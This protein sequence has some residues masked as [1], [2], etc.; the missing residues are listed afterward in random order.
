MTFKDLRMMRIRNG[1][2]AKEMAERLNVSYGWS[3]QLELYYHGP[4]IREWR[5]KYEVA[6]RGLIEEKREAGRAGGDKNGGN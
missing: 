2:S 4:S 6:L 1:I 3:R 5:E